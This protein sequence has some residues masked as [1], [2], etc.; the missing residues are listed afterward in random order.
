MEHNVNSG[1]FL[2]SHKDY[3]GSVEYDE[4]EDIFYGVV[5]DLHDVVT[6]YSKSVDDLQQAFE[7]SIWDYLDFCRERNEEPEK[8][9]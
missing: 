1:A 2:L 5:Q 8:P 3:T 9:V 4:E 7:D 6:F